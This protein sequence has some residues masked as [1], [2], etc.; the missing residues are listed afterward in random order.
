LFGRLKRGAA[1]DGP[2]E[3]HSRQVIDQFRR[4]AVYFAKLPG[5]EEATQVLL[6]M[7]GVTAADEVLD[8]ACGAGAVACAAAGVARRVR[9]RFLSTPWRSITSFRMHAAMARIFGL[10]AATS[11]SKNPRNRGLNRGG[12]AVAPA[13]E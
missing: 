8:V 1:C 2:D 11:R 6:R 7:A 4:Q 12:A 5:H 3:P 9:A 13:S 10:P